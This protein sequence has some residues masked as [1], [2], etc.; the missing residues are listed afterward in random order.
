MDIE[1]TTSTTL[2][3]CLLCPTRTTR[4]A[5]SPFLDQDIRLCRDCTHKFENLDVQ[6]LV[7]AVEERKPGDYQD[8]IDA[9]FG[10]D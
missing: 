1:I 3:T 4:I 6:H 10:G 8:Q 7:L 2:A 9:M 5:K